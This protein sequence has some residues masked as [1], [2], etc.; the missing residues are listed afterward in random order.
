LKGK[1]TSLHEANQ[2][3]TFVYIMGMKD[4]ELYFVADSEDPESEDYS[5]PGQ[6]YYE[7]SLAFENAF[8]AQASGAEGPSGDRWGTWITG[9]APIIVNENV[10]AA[11]GIDV[12]ANEFQKQR[13]TYTLLP[14][15][16]TLILIAFVY[17]GM[18][19]RRQEQEFLEIKSRFVAVA[20]HDIRSPLTGL[21]WAMQSLVQSPRLQ[22]DD[23]KLVS[24]I[25]DK[26]QHLLV[27]ANDILDTL[28]IDTVK[29]NVIKADVKLS[30]PIHQAVES[31]NFYARQERVEL[32]K[33]NIPEDAVVRGDMSKL[34]QMFM[35]ILSNAIKYSR[36]HTDIKIDYSADA[37]G[38]VI[39]ITDHGIGIPKN[40]QK[41]VFKGF[42]RAKNAE[43]QHAHGT[44]LGL[45]LVKR[46]AELHGGSVSIAS[47]EN[48]GTRVTVKLPRL[49]KGI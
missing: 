48:K 25:S 19:T 46:I 15:I 29:A 8:G 43:A 17:L 1:L 6:V 11:V 36:P 47:E 7:E 31:I 38:Y 33:G 22:P 3:S 27:S 28:S 37:A 18:R 42:Y 30:E 12:D 9:V 24:E 41:H 20:S 40:E 45:Y 23:K 34:Q 5:P 26:I 49:N 16:A 44:G 13:S 32:V 39:T 21:A 2:D 14:I 10:V 35:N 4:G